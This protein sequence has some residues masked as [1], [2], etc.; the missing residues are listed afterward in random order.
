MTNFTT[1]ICRTHFFVGLKTR[2][3]GLDVSAA[4]RL[5]SYIMGKLGNSSFALFKQDDITSPPPHFCSRLY[6]VYTL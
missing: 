4:L 5:W 1:E 2:V 6:N 3:D